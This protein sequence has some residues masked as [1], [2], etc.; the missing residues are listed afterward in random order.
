[1]FEEKIND[2]LGVSK[3]G[4][5]A[6]KIL[7]DKQG[8]SV[9]YPLVKSSG[10]LYQLS[11]FSGSGKS[12]LLFSLISRKKKNGIR[13]SYRKLF[14]DIVYCSPSS[15]T[16]K[17]NPLDDLDEGKKFDEFNNSVLDKIDEI[18]LE[19][20]E[21]DEPKHTLLILDDVS[22]ALR[23]NRPLENRL[24]NLANNRRHKNLSIIYITQV[25]NQS[26]VGLR[27]NLNLLFIFKPKTKKEMDS[28]IDDYF[29]LDRK[30]VIKLFDFVYKTRYDFMIIDFTLRENPDIEYFRNF[31]K[32]LIYNKDA[33]RN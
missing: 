16:L 5:S 17:N 15:N 2:K 12:T 4:M 27:K 28:L 29:M 31:N 20:M 33:E 21:E 30:Q 19:N 25:F 13:Q 24:V 26:P 1:M 9:P 14:D 18:I 22:V 10:F 23:K 8:Q 11:G 6:D 7:M 32:V 3:I